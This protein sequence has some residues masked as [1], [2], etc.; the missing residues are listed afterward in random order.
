[1]KNYFLL[2]VVLLFSMTI[3][4]NALYSQST[5]EKYIA[6]NN[7][8][9]KIVK[10]TTQIVYVAKEKI[11]SNQTLNIFGLN[12]I[13][14]VDSLGNGI[15]D[16]KLFKKEYFEKMNKEY[17]DRC[18]TGTGIWCNHEFWKKDD[19]TY[20]NVILESMNNNKGIELILDKYKRTDISVYG[21]SE[22][23]YYQDKKYVV[24]TVLKSYMAGYSHFIIVMKK[25]KDKWIV[26]HKGENPNIIN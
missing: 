10:D 8:L 22:P 1:M 13:M 5:N 15:G 3:F 7:Y 2:Q 23:I 17:K 18:E 4:S 24:F 9:E 20:N 12:D 19:F 11:N 14:T 26:T 16:S 6:L 21:F 25:N